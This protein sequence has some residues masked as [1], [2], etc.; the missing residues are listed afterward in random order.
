VRAG[1]D[2]SRFTIRTVP[3]LLARSKAWQGYEDAARPVVKAIE[4]LAKS[5]K[6]PGKALAANKGAAAEKAPIRTKGKPTGRKRA[7]A[8]RARS[9][10]PHS[11]RL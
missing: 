5:Q 6:T 9:R 1:L 7:T 8:T 3:G 4:L 11:E 2:P 10:S